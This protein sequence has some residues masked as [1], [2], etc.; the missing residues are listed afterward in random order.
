MDME[1]LVAITD[2]ID[3]YMYTYFL[4][5]LLIGAGVW[6]TIRT[7]GVQFRLIKDGLKANNAQL[8]AFCGSLDLSAAAESFSEPAFAELMMRTASAMCERATG[9]FISSQSASYTP[10]KTALISAESAPQASGATA[11]EISP[12]G[13]AGAFAPAMAWRSREACIRRFNPFS[14]ACRA[15]LEKSS[16]PR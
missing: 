7:K 1:S 10:S 8:D 4:V 2:T 14:A 12:Y 13:K 16:V 3:T 9:V 6:F 5:F 15:S 11:S